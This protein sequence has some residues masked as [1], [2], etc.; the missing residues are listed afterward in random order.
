MTKAQKF[1]QI[2]GPV[3]QKIEENLP[4]ESSEGFKS[5]AELLWQWFQRYEKQLELNEMIKHSQ[6]KKDVEGGDDNHG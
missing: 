4:T 6:K 5:L 3:A 1:R 2:V